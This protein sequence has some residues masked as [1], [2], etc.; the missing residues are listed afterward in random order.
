MHHMLL[1]SLSKF[2]CVYECMCRFQWPR[3]LRRGSTATRLLRSWV[4]IP[5]GHGCLSVVSVVCCQIE[6]S[7][8]SLSPVQRSPTDCGVSL[9]MIS[10]KQNP[11]VWGGDQDPLGGYMRVCK[12]HVCSYVCVCMCV[13][14]Y[15][16][17]AFSVLSNTYNY[18][19]NKMW[20]CLYVCSPTYS[21]RAMCLCNCIYSYGCSESNVC[22]VNLSKAYQKKMNS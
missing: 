1:S 7:A 5:P 6:V 14:I 12:L 15:R 3:G 10:K 11:L 22:L 9:C 8:T 21:Y 20:I 19:S 2:V 16:R 13:C 4:R 18:L 17:P